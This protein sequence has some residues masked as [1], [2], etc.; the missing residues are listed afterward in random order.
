MGGLHMNNHMMGR[1]TAS[2]RLGIHLTGV[3]LQQVVFTGI[4]EEDLKILHAQEALFGTITDLVVD[5]LY[6]RLLQEPGPAAIIN[7]HSTRDRLKGTQRWYFQSLTDGFID[8][9]FF[10]RRL[11]FGRI[12]SRIGLTT[13]WYLVTYM[14]YLQIAT[15]QLQR[16]LPDQ[17]ANVV[18]SM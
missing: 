18:M 13:N 17:W 12:H 6:E 9:S 14:L 5:G 10:E 11:H 1:T 4:T 8:E 2:D 7:S 3:R 15:Q 16:A